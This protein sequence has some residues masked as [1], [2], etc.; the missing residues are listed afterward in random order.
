MDSAV[1]VINFFV[2][3]ERLETSRPTL[4]GEEIKGLARVDLTD[5]LELRDAD[6]RIP[7]ADSQSV[8]MKEGLHFVAYPGGRDS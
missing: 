1:A 7:I 2:N 8:E 4:T 3:R 6:R 5:L